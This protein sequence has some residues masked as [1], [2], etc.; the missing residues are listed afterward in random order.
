[1]F[2]SES[3]PQKSVHLAVAFMGSNPGFVPHSKGKK[4]TLLYG[5][6]RILLILFVLCKICVAIIRNITSP[7]YV[8]MSLNVAQI[9]LYIKGVQQK[10]C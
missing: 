3:Q 10:Y 9:D 5:H 8:T 2:L 7:S 1:M 4:Q 6:P